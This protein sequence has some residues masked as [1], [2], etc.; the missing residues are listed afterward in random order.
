MYYL[1]TASNTPVTEETMPPVPQD[2]RAPPRA[3]SRLHG[4][5]G[6]LLTEG[7]AL[8]R[9]TITPESEDHSPLRGEGGPPCPP[10]GGRA[11]PRAA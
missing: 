3:A 8:P 10:Q 5:Q 7:E 6:Q 4:F 1:F 9:S 2:A 11:C